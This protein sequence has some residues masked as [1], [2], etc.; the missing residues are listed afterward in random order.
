MREVK[1]CVLWKSIVVLKRAGRDV[2]QRRELI[3]AADV[4]DPQR[5]SVWVS[6]VIR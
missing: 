3:A 2:T 6:G 1:Y 5:S 4:T